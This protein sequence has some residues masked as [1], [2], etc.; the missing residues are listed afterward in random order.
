MRSVFTIKWLWLSKKHCEENRRL[1]PSLSACLDQKVPFA[2]PA[3]G[4]M[5]IDREQRY[6]AVNSLQTQKSDGLRIV[7]SRVL[8]SI[9]LPAHLTAHHSRECDASCS[10]GAATCFE[11]SFRDDAYTVRLLLRTRSQRTER[12]LCLATGEWTSLLGRTT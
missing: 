6:L 7:A 2:L 5:A 8:H 4:G 3:L 12:L 11:L 1:S 10:R 9:V